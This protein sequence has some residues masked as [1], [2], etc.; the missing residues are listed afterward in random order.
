VTSSRAEAELLRPDRTKLS[1]RVPSVQDCTTSGPASA[2]HGAPKSPLWLP[3]LAYQTILACASCKSDMPWTSPAD[4][5]R[6]ALANQ[7]RCLVRLGTV[8]QSDPHDP[9]KE[10]PATANRAFAS[11]IDNVRLVH[12]VHKLSVHPRR[13]ARR[14]PSCH[15][16][17]DWAYLEKRRVHWRRG[18]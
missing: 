1:S 3:S 16:R 8:P 10:D 4:V 15:F 9:V 17:R 12:S 2:R 7:S 5:D 18:Y 14:R 13:R 6:V 11:C